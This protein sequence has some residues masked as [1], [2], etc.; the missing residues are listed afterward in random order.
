MQSELRHGAWWDRVENVP[1]GDLMEGRFTRLFPDA[2]AASFADTDL[3]TLAAA[4]TAAADI[5][6]TPES[7]VDP[8]ENPGMASAFTYFGQFIDHDLTLDLTSHLREKLS[9]HQLQR[10]VD[11]RTPRFDLDSVYGR[12]PSEQPYLYQADGIQMQLGAPLSGNPHDPRSADLPRGPTGRALIGDPRDDENRIVAQ[13]H[14]I[15]LRFH[16]AVAVAMPGATFED[17]R[18][19]VRWHYQWVVINDFLPTIIQRP[20]VT[21]VFPHLEGGASIESAPPRFTITQLRH[22]LKLMP[23]EFSVAVYRFG[24]STVRPLYRLNDTITRRQIFSTAADPAGDLGGFRP[25]PSDWA[26]D[27]QFFIDLDHGLA[28]PPPTDANDPIVRRPQHAYKIDTSL[29]N[30]LGLLPPTV[31]SNPSSLARR[32]LLRGVSF[33]L[34][35]GQTVARLLDVTPLDDDQLLIGKATK[36]EPLRPLSSLIPAMARNCPLW[37]YVLSEA[38]TTSWALDSGNP[39]KDTIP[40]RLG[41]VGGHIVAEVFAA[42]LLGDPTSFLSEDPGFTPLPQFSYGSKFGLAELITVALG[43]SRHVTEGSDPVN[44]AQAIDARRPQK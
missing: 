5:P 10:L 43:C 14:G 42:L 29:V 2:K 6:P 30:P 32:N 24:H 27:W 8:E 22:G 40:T 12:G 26:I 15:M 20:T 3:T 44:A 38:H 13:L 19:S 11:F 25:I 16:N 33:G 4:M 35:S 39:D 37:T 23:V 17:I 21:D 31:A 9:R 34:P 28:P 1:A 41:P 36:R 7:V 18:K